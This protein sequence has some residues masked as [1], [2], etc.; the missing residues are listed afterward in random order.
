MMVSTTRPAASSRICP[1]ARRR[2]AS[3]VTTISRHEAT[4]IHAVPEPGKA[5][6]A[7][8]NTCFGNW[9]QPAMPFQDE[10]LAAAGLA[11]Q[12]L[13][14]PMDMVVAIDNAG[15]PDQCPEQRQRGL[16]T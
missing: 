14:E 5:S 9:F 15:L 6:P 4:E 1:I 11:G 13:L 10:R 7:E 2:L 16:D 3:G 12:V 8:R